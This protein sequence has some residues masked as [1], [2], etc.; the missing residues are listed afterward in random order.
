MEN[1][2]PLMESV[3]SPVEGDLSWF[4]VRA[5]PREEHIAAASLRRLEGMDVLNPR[6]KF[7]RPTVRGPVWVTESM[8]PGYIFARFN[9]RQSLDVVR[10]SFGVAGVVHFGLFWPIVP[11][12]TVEGIRAVVGEEEVRFVEPA[13]KVG[14]DVEVATGSF[15]WRQAASRVFMELLRGL[16]RREIAWLCFWNFWGAKHWWNCR[17]VVFLT[18]ALA[19]S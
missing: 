6:I 12:E 8:F 7:R 19:I 11:D 18:T 2:L 13:L 4:C 10:Y 17:W 9:L 1:L 14:D 15:A 16:C 3:L 5:R